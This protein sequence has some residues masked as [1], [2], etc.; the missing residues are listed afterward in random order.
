M[1]VQVTL[2]LQ[3]QVGRE[4]E[5]PGVV[6]GMARDAEHDA[7]SPWW[8]TRLPLNSPGWTSMFHL[9]FFGV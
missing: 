4:R 9:C 1:A 8:S 3:R 5:G 6:R 2:D 7:E